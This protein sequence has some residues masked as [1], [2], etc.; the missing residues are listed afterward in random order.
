[1]KGGVRKSGEGA[2]D[3]FQRNFPVATMMP[4][5]AYLMQVLHFPSLETLNVQLDTVWEASVHCTEW[6]NGTHMSVSS[7]L[8]IPKF[9]RWALFLLFPCYTEKAKDG[10]HKFLST[11]VPTAARWEGRTCLHPNNSFPPFSTAQLWE[12]SGWLWEGSRIFWSVLY[13]FFKE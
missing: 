12:S 2:W 10:K 5:N 8:V 13:I 4:W 9:K 11:Q 7:H 3:R 1:M 6:V